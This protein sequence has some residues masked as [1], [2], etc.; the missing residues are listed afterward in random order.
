MSKARAF[1]LAL[2]VNNEVRVCI[3][4]NLKV[5]MMLAWGKSAAPRIHSHALV[6]DG[7]TRGRSRQRALQP[8]CMDCPTPYRNPL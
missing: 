4:W 3:V 1:C 7:N 2:L 6:T 8:C 5:W